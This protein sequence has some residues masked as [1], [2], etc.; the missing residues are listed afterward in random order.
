MHVASHLQ[1]EREVQRTHA[2]H[3]KLVGSTLEQDWR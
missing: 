1:P 3:D 2:S